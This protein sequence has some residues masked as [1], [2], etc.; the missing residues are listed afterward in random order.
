[1]SGA[2]GPGAPEAPVSYFVASFLPEDA[3]TRLARLGVRLPPGV[4]PVPAAH[5]HLTWRSFEGLPH[6]LLA[7]LKEGLAA[8]ATRHGPVRVELLGGGVFPAG[9]VWARVSPKPAVSALQAE[10]DTLLRALGLPG[11]GW[12]F[13]PHITLGQGPPGTRT[14]AVLHDLSARLTLS[15]F[16]LTTTGQQPY[17]VVR[18]FPLAG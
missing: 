11:A 1:M 18:H 13:V 8:V 10:I 7:P 6:G 9:A 12:P 16:A 2:A 5:L 4:A 17:R 3:A 14:P 15:D